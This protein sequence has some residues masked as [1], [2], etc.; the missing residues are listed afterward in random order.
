MAYK[1]KITKEEV[2]LV[3][4]AI[5]AEWKKIKK[6]KLIPLEEIKRKFKID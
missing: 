1:R 6:D 4:K 5:E 2:M 3:A